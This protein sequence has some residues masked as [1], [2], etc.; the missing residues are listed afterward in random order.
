MNFFDFMNNLH[1]DSEVITE[2]GSHG[3]R[4]FNGVL[5]VFINGK[6]IDASAKAEVIDVEISKEDFDA[7]LESG[8]VLEGVDYHIMGVQSGDDTRVV[9]DSGV[10]GLRYYNGSLQVKIDDSWVNASVP[11]IGTING[12]SLSED[13]T[14][15]AEDV[16]ASDSTHTHDDRYYTETEIDNKLAG[17]SDT[18]HTHS[19]YLTSHQDISGKADIVDP[20]FTGAFSQNRKADTTVGMYSHAE[21]YNTAAMAKYSHT[22]GYTTKASAS[23][24]HAEGYNTVTYGAYSHTEGYG[25]CTNGDCSHAE[26]SST[27]TLA[28]CSHVEGSHT[29]ASNF[30]SHAGGHYNANMTTGG[31]SNNTTGTAFV[32]GNGTSDSAK[33][34]AFSVQY[35]GVVKAQSTI[36]A[37]TTADYAEYFEW[38]DKNP[39]NEDRVGYFVTLDG[40]EIRIANDE[41]DYI[42]GV[43][44]GEPFVLGNG[45]CDVWNGMHLRDKFRRTIYEPAPL[46]EEVIDEEGHPT[47]EFKEVFDE[48]GNPVYQG[49]RPVLNPNYDHTKPYTNRAD[50]P[51][52]S[53]VGMLGVLPVRHDGTAKVNGYVTVNKEGIATACEKSHENS[54]RVI[55]EN[56]D[57]VVEII[58]R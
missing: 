28:N 24:S 31:A 20:V 39:D 18:D 43:V 42:L 8:E 7:I 45:D 15:T 41:D 33:S 40:N 55:H 38:I 22:E 34:N 6:W 47:G 27:T 50:R 3:I 58:F 19:Q 52:W 51:E 30:A 2:K 4:Y 1:L 48:E 11:N 56:A 25:T 23:Y 44:S 46:V 32:I 14:L 13:I 35:S 57:D 16:G 10:H 29:I 36:T 21:G 17:K 12:K 53:A 26:G 9:S 54:Y 49:T 37:S 5:Q